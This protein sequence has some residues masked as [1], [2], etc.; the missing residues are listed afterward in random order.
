M[1]KVEKYKG[2][3][4]TVLKTKGKTKFTFIDLFAGIGGFRIALQNL[5]GECVFSSEWDKYSQD[6]YEYNFGERPYG[7]ITKEET[8]KQIPQKFDL[9]C[10]GFPCQAFSIAGK[11]GGFDDTRGTL[12]YDV[13]EIIRRHKPKA[14][15]LENVKGLHNHNGGRT[16]NTILNVLREDLG[17]FVPDPEVINAKYFGVPQNRERVF[18]V[19]F[20][21][22]L[23]INTFKY[24][25]SD[26]ITKVLEDILEKE[27][28]DARY[29]MSN[30]Y[31]QTLV[32]HK[33]R[34]ESKGNGFGYEILKRDGVANAIVVGGMGRERNLVIDKRLK[35]F[36]P[37][38][39]IKG[40][41]NREGIRRLTPAECAALQGFPAA[42][43][44]QH[45]VANAQ[46]YKQFGNSV[47]VPAIEATAKKI[48]EK[49]ITKKG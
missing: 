14:I 30:Q 45:I 36:K 41:I 8:K 22:D 4:R 47:A 3:K 26:K 18:I 16:L 9:L 49:I 2:V 33:A 43:Q 21:K 11:R 7:D 23:K 1:E 34:H 28:V 46:S 24:P 39:K 17:Y 37:T 19:G 6:V 31:W 40:G 38:T 12:F 32:K 35:N 29:Y 27:V 15:F 13:A 42:F 20:R 10:G 5:G 44:F 48:L 25:H